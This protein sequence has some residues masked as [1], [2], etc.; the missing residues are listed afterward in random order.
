[1]CKYRLLLLFLCGFY[2][3]V[4]VGSS[5]TSSDDSDPYASFSFDDLMGSTSSDDDT[6]SDLVTAADDEHQANEAQQV[7]DQS[8]FLSEDYENIVSQMQE[9]NVMSR[10]SS[11]VGQLSSGTDVTDSDMNSVVTDLTGL[12]NQMITFYL[13]ENAPISATIGNGAYSFYLTIVLLYVSRLRYLS[14]QVLVVAKLG[15]DYTKQVS[16]LLDAFSQYESS[17]QDIAKNF[18][19][20]SDDEWSSLGS[21]MQSY[22]EL[23]PDTALNDYYS[24]AA[25]VIFENFYSVVELAANMQSDLYNEAMYAITMYD[26]LLGVSSLQVGNSTYDTFVDYQIAFLQKLYTV[27]QDGLQEQE[28]LIDFVGKTEAENEVYFQDKATLYQA[29]TDLFK[30]IDGFSSQYTS[31]SSGETS[32]AAK[33]A[34]FDE[35]YSLLD[36]IDSTYTTSAAALKTITAK[37]DCITLITN[38]SSAITSCTTVQSDLTLIGDSVH[39]NQVN[40]YK[41]NLQKIFD[42]AFV[43]YFWLT[44]LND[45][46]NG[47]AAFKAA[48]SSFSSADDLAFSDNVKKID[49]CMQSLHDLCSDTE[50]NYSTKYSLLSILDAVIGLLSSE[51]T[52]ITAPDDDCSITVLFTLQNVVNRMNNFTN[53]YLKIREWMERIADEVS[54]TGVDSPAIYLSTVQFLMEK[55]IIEAKSLDDLYSSYDYIGNY[56]QSFSLNCMPTGEQTFYDMAVEM[57]FYIF[58]NTSQV[59]QPVE[60]IMYY[61]LLQLFGDNLSNHDTDYIVQD[62]QTLSGEIDIVSLADAIIANAQTQGWTD[63]DSLEGDDD[64]DKDVNIT[65]SCGWSSVMSWS[66]NISW[67]SALQLYQIAYQV[68]KVSGSDDAGTLYAKYTQSIKDYVQK[69]KQLVSGENESPLDLLYVY[70]LLFINYNGHGDPPVVDNSSQ[71]ADTGTDTDQTTG[72]GAVADTSSETVSNTNNYASSEAGSGV[73]TNSEAVTAQAV[74]DDA[75]TSQVAINS[76]SSGDVQKSDDAGD[77]QS[78]EQDDQPVDPLANKQAVVTAIIGLFSNDDKNGFFDILSSRVSDFQNE[79]DINNLVTRQTAVNSLTTSFTNQ[80]NAEGGWLALSDILFSKTL[81]HMLSFSVNTNDGSTTYSFTYQDNNTSGNVP[82]LAK[83][84]SDRAEAIADQSYA[85]GQ[86][87][88]DQKDFSTA[89]QRYSDAVTQY[90]IVIDQLTPSDSVL[91]KYASAQTRTEASLMVSLVK[92]S[93][94]NTVASIPDIA[95]DYVLILDSLTVPTIISQ[96]LKSEYLI[97]GD[98]GKTL[99][100]TTEQVQDV[101]EM[102]ALN[103]ELTN[104]GYTYDM[105]YTLGTTTRV[106]GLKPY[107]TQVCDTIEATVDN[108]MSIVKT[109]MSISDDDERMTVTGIRDA[110]SEVITLTLINIPIAPWQPYYTDAPYANSYYGIAELLFQSGSANVAVGTASYAPG[111]D[112]TAAQS[113]R[114]Y[115]AATTLATAKLEV[116][117]VEDYM[118]TL[119]SAVAAATTSSALESL[120]DEFTE[121]VSDKYTNA[122]SILLGTSGVKGY[123]SDNSE[124]DYANDVQTYAMNLY[125]TYESNISQL[126]TGDPTTDFYTT[127]L[128]ALNLAYQTHASFAT[129]DSTVSDLNYKSAELLKNTGDTCMAYETVGSSG[130]PQYYYSEA[131][132]YYLDAL[133]QYQ[134]IGDVDKENEVMLLEYEAYAKNGAQRV[135]N[136]I[137][138]RDNQIQYTNISGEVIST[139]FADILQDENDFMNQVSSIVTENTMDLNERNLYTNLT[140]AFLNGIMSLSVASGGP[141]LIDPNASSDDSSDDSSDASDDT[142]DQPTYN[143]SNLHPDVVT[144]FTKYN[145]T[146]GTEKQAVQTQ[147]DDSDDTDDVDKGFGDTLSGID[148]W[149]GSGSDDDSD[150]SDDDQ[151]Q[152]IT[153]YSVDITSMDIIEQTFSAAIEGITTFFNTQNKDAMDCLLGIYYNGASFIYIFDYLGGVAGDT[154]TD[155]LKNMQAKWQTLGQVLAAYSVKLQNP[156]GAYF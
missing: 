48:V 97:T 139:T 121:N 81:D 141:T 28:S 61:F 77:G 50:N 79:T 18:P 15:A 108:Y 74:E 93:N 12:L 116:D 149:A 76:D 84:L 134:T 20:S 138:T 150:D 73:S 75:S 85:D 92:R 21:S 90:K 123:Y 127:V 22:Y 151:P 135:N 70:Y 11:L 156:S 143:Q 137:Y 117:E 99:T 63:Y 65:K 153:I 122:I 31:L 136:Y 142:T 128:H 30:G 98:D 32:A 55:M 145:V 52:M 3:S 37:S 51:S 57:I 33:L 104:A 36:E 29:A 109:A 5:T 42:V 7:D 59:G 23:L 56:I 24:Q 44:F 1:M 131:I 78:N 26:D 124:T 114:L 80:S 101:L 106:S 43:E 146:M 9:S 27:V 115:T 35:A 41:N 46:D 129:D 132:S 148:D 54:N 40:E 140:D 58:G 71:D 89:H 82:D 120:V 69:Y 133:D 94:I 126:L 14:D 16:A 19:N 25:D 17:L 91:S 47:A 68:A 39:L 83:L 119:D 6:P 60:S 102:I 95:L 2:G 96:N 38:V 4:L 118:S 130:I 125:S 10:F 112:D 72:I 13:S 154:E 64:F 147:T 34:A 8:I 88:S 100:W 67:L 110:S 152:T 113:M 62:L 144:L 103:S 66:R 53:Y 86:T 105:L 49:D 45:S 107:S 155:R 87:A 111:N